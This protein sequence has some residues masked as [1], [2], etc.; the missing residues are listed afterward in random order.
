MLVR[1]LMSS[2]AVTVSPSLRLKAALQLLAEHDIT[3]LPVVSPSG[4]ILGVVSEADLIRDLV[5]PDRRAQVIPTD[6]EPLRGSVV[7]DVMTAHAVT[8]TPNTDLETAVDLMTSTSVKSL[9][10]VDER[11]VVRGVLSR[12]DVVQVYARADHALER[13][14]Q[15]MLASGGLDDWL[16]EVEDGVVEVTGS[17]DPRTTNLARALAGAVPGIIAVRMVGAERSASRG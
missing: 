12:R 3:S 17:A 6:K 4:R 14:V 9:P 15:A 7:E 16:C 1:E 13:D 8:V 10:V 5:A 11:G 2:S